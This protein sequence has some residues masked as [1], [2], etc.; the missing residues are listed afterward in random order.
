MI[1]DRVLSQLVLSI[2]YLVSGGDKRLARSHFYV[3]LQIIN[4]P[5]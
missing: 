4:V 3:L 2:S 1:Y 5:P